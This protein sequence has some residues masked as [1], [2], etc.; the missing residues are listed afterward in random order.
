MVVLLK[1]K[2]NIIK[3]VCDNVM[4]VS[5]CTI[6]YYNYIHIPYNNMYGCFECL[7]SLLF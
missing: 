1:P 6:L 3:V 2:V 5:A 4:C 7:L